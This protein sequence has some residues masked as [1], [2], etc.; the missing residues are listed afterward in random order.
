[1]AQLKTVKHHRFPPEIIQTAASF[2]HRIKLS[3]RNVVD[4]TSWSVI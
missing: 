3:H 2:H 1:M 4:G